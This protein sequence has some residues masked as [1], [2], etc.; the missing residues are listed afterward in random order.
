V[1]ARLPLR[2]DPANN[3]AERQVQH[4]RHRNHPVGPTFRQGLDEAPPNNVAAEPEKEEGMTVVETME[5]VE[6]NLAELERGREGADVEEY[7]GLIKRGTCFLPYL[8]ERGLAFAPSRFIGYQEN[9]LAIHA[10]NPRRDGRVTNAALN[11]IYGISPAPDSTLE[12]RYLDF[13]S[14]LGLIPSSTG[15]FGVARKYWVTPEVIELLEQEQATAIAGNAG[16]S[17]TE[18]RQLVLARVGQGL[19]RQRLISKWGQC[20][21]TACDCLE[22]LRASH[23]KPW[24][25]SD[26]A[27]RLDMFNGL[28][29]S[30]NM[31]A[32]FDSGLITFDEQGAIQ[33]S[34]WLSASAR[35]ALGCTE[36]LKVRL[37]PE[38]AK[39]LSWHR[40]NIFQGSNA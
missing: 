6:Q 5:Q 24:R 19:F 14:T 7:L 34:P 33:I 32:L 10:D 28:L 38:H 26:N 8:S 23:I 17:D 21:V 1:N 20:A 40:D 22:V 29:L 36:T 25:V 4:W 30:P 18:K 39:Y 15:A 9:R 13:C 2:S 31:D 35:H 27:E 12:R 3:P 37:S 16:L 11:G